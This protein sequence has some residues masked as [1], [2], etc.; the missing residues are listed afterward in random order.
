MSCVRLRSGA[1][2]SLLVIGLT[3][4]L[5]GAT[6]RN[7]SPAV[8]PQNTASRSA[9]M[10]PSNLGAFAHRMTGGRAVCVESSA[11]QASSLR[12]RDTP[13]T[14]LTPDAEQTPRRGLRIILRGTAQLQDSPVAIEAF[15]RAA[16]RWETVI[17]TVATIV[18]DVDFGPT[19]FGNQ[20]DSDV[21]AATDAQVL[22]GNC[23]Y[24]A[25]R[26]ALISGPHAPE[27][28]SLYAALP[29]EAVP[30]DSGE[31]AGLTSSS[32]V[33]RA[34][35][36]INP[37]AQPD[38]ELSDFGPPPAIGFNSTFKFEF[39]PDDGI[40][41][42]KLDFEAIALHEI[43]HVLG[44]ISFAGQQEM[45]PSVEMEPSISDLF[46]MRPDS[47]NSGFT[48][49]PR[50]LSS[51]GE[52]SFYA[53][54][55]KLAL[56]T[57]R[58][59]GTGGDGR[60][61]SHWK[62]SRLTGKYIGVMDPT[63][64]RGEHQFMTDEDVSVLEAIG[65]RAKNLIDPTTVLVLSSAQPQSGVISAPPAP[66][67]GAL[68]HTHYSIVVPPGASQVK[69]D[70]IGNQDVDLFA[71]FG[72][73]VFNNGHTVA[74]DFGSTTESGSEHIIVTTSS[75]PTL[76]QGIYYIAV[77]NF[78]PGDADFT[79]TA[80][81][82]GGDITRAPAI[83]DIG[84]HLEGD[85]LE[86]DCAVAD[87]DGDLAGAEVS[88]LDEANV[89]IGAPSTFAIDSGDQ[90]RV[91]TKLTISGMSVI[92][93]ARLARVVF[94]DGRGNRSAEAIVD[95]GKGEAGGLTL[96]SASFAG[97]KLI[98]KVRGTAA[99]LELEINGQV[100]DRK[101]KV[102]GSSSKLTIKGNASQLSLHP[103]ANRIRVKNAD[104]W[105]NIL[106]LQI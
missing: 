15:K 65:Y 62:D 37:A 91:E 74:A 77:A 95:L 24:P 47:I 87:R 32:A 97:K 53:G 80:T 16:A 68:S 55:P 89:P 2:A 34:L 10:G 88:M 41:P 57:G 43:A 45:N 99:S 81:V 86:L 59:D 63:I 102:N 49:A 46:R 73:A 5:P 42:D 23:L 48:A 61:P 79:V 78:G 14:V 72:H 38:D 101:I 70:L 31:F 56:S 94:S 9:W 17:Q 92:P 82:T 35:D 20:F 52:Q 7:E 11:G 40:E 54:G 66:G 76:L 25:V 6:A 106:I 3:S 71:R 85:V 51:G 93:G 36:V 33:L 27:Q 26:A 69:I 13:L 60:Q 64:G 44:F 90:T 28:K 29:P 84:A 75:S 39:E 58:P 50:V 104:G 18:I 103:G 100:S 30:T 21:V 19:L 8:L 1:L 83:F 22:G 4:V 105:S 67:L 98:L 96:T 12:E